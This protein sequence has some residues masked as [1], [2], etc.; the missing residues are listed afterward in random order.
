MTNGRPFSESEKKTLES[1]AFI[2]EGASELVSRIDPFPLS[3]FGREPPGKEERPA[4]G[5]IRFYV[6]TLNSLRH[7]AFILFT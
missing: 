1:V 6:L 7:R 5:L 4:G 2:L 3:E